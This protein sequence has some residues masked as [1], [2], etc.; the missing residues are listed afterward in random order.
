LTADVITLEP[1]VWPTI[2]RSQGS[3]YADEQSAVGAKVAGRVAQVHVD[4]GDPVR[5]GDA[6]ATLDEEEFRLLVSQAEAQLRQARSAVGLRDEEPVDRLE[7]ENSPPVQEQRALWDEAKS[8]LARAAKLRDQDAIAAGEYDQAA[9]AERVAEARYR[10]AINA[11]HEKIALIAV[12]QAELSLARQRCRDAVITAPL[13][14]FVQQRHVAVGS[15]LTV[16]QTIAVLVRNDPLRFRGTVPERHAQALAVGQEVRLQIESV[17][18]PVTAKIAR[19][20]P[21]LDQLTRALVFEAEVVNRDHQLRSGLFAQAEVVIDAHALAMVLPDSAIL[22]FAGTQKVWKVVDGVAVEQEVLTGTRQF[23]SRVLFEGVAAGDRI[24][25]DASQ[26]RVAR[27]EAKAEA[28]RVSEKEAAPPEL[29]TVPKP[30]A[31]GELA[32]ERRDSESS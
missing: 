11:V 30:A 8:V 10:S 19:V 14:G 17:A 15:Y 24:L 2:V 29:R 7:P 1:T 31:P 28:P 22:E 25:R 16:G 21:T 4:L 12:R 6:I 5:A 18:A 20:S 13:D 9:A 27:I 26:G 32:A 23:G 3:L